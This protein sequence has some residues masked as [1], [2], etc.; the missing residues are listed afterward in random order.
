MW[1]INDFSAYADFSGWPNRG[2][3]A[4][5][6]CMHSTRS[7]WLKH[8]KK[9]CYMRHRRYLPMD[10][11]WRRNK[12]IFDGNQELECAP[13]VQS[14]DEIMRQLERM[15][16]GDENTGK[17]KTGDKKKGKKQLLMM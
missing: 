10:H 3:K 9:I 5:P 4:C 2:E 11:P 8:D 13:H 16:F 1:I 7:R 15:V 14:G 17:A 6:C 12:R